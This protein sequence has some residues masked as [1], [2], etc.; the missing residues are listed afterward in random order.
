MANDVILETTQLTKA[1]DGYVAVL[2]VSLKVPRGAI[3]A[4]IGPNGAG[5]RNRPSCYTARPGDVRLALQRR[6]GH[7]FDF[8]RSI[9]CWR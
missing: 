1:F 8:R 9:V 6:R 2:D 4:L 5:K 3:H 7:S